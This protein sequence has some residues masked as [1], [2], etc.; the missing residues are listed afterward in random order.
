VGLA[1]LG[2][3]WPSQWQMEA[4]VDEVAERLAAPRVDTHRGLGRR[5]LDLYARGVVALHPRD[6]RVASEPGKH[7][8]ATRWSRRQIALSHA[9]TD[10]RHEVRNLPPAMAS[11]AAHCDGQTDRASLALRFADDAAE[12]GFTWTGTPEQAVQQ[13]LEGLT[14]RAML[15]A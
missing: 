13:A 15:L 4:W 11:V 5:L 12:R 9:V 8:R 14:Q 7:P 2:A 10:L 6:L 1:V 3:R